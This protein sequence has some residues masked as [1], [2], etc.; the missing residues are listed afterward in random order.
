[1]QLNHKIGVE[2]IA[3]YYITPHRLRCHSRNLPIVGMVQCAPFKFPV[4]RI[5][6]RVLLYGNDFFES[7][8]LFSDLTPWSC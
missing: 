3:V 2:N 4:L 6:L 8:L 5:S 1:M 7:F